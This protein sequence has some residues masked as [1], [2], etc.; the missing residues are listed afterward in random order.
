M[1]RLPPTTLRSVAPHRCA[2][3]K[4][5]TG[6]RDGSACERLSLTAGV[7]FPDRSVGAVPESQS[8]IPQACMVVTQLPTQRNKCN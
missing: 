4:G 6:R 8:R 2:L 5:E 7:R 3:G 1:P